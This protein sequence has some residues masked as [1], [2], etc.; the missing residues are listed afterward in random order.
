MFNK[1]LEKIKSDINHDINNNNEKP[2]KS[3]APAEIIIDDIIDDDIR[4]NSHISFAGVT[5]EDDG[6]LYATGGRVLISVGIGDSIKEAQ[7]RA[8]A[9]CGQVHFIGK[10]C[11]TDIA[12]QALE[13]EG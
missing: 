8:Y 3:S 10:H 11:R 5:R 1:D 4:A 6:K 2:Y 7:S 9:L 13:L 12:Y